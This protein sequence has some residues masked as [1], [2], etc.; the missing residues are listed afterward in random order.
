VDTEGVNDSVSASFRV[1]NRGSV[2]V[3][4][5]GG[6]ATPARRRK[7][8]RNAATASTT[9]ATAT[10]SPTEQTPTA[11]NAAP[12]V[13]VFDRRD[14]LFRKPRVGLGRLADQHVAFGCPA[15]A[16]QRG[17][18][19]LRQARIRLAL[20]PGSARERARPGALASVPSKSTGRR[21]FDSVIAGQARAVRT[22][23]PAASQTN[24][25]IYTCGDLLVATLRMENCPRSLKSLVPRSLVWTEG[26]YREL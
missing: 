11:S 3:S 4:T 21:C 22:A 18:A 14:R 1:K 15:V 6:A 7:A 8:R 9:T 5:G 12:S 26:N 16:R 20:D 13:S 2:S 17:D 10:A 25:P 24:G 23:R 19:F